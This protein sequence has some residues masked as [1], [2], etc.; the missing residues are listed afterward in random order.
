MEPAKALRTT[1]IIESAREE[2]TEQFQKLLENP[3]SLA[4]QL[5]K[6][7]G[8]ERSLGITAKAL[9]VMQD[10]ERVFCGTRVLSDM[11]PVFTS[12]GD[13]AVAGFVVHNL[14][15]HYLQDGNYKEF[16]VALDTSDLQELK[17]AIARA[18][19][20]GEILKATLKKSD[21]LYLEVE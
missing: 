3:Q 14:S 18:E 19:Q 17:M 15:I 8:L 13:A 21:F 1:G 16:F 9:G 5:G 2:K 7:L 11:R 20:K 10:Y 6:L 12:A 4:S